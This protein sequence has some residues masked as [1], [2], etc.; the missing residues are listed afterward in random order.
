MEILKLYKTRTMSTDILHYFCFHKNI[1]AK[2]I[3]NS[4]LDRNLKPSGAYLTRFLPH[5]CFC[6]RSDL[7]S[8]L[9]LTPIFIFQSP[10]QIVFFDSNI[11]FIEPTSSHFILPFPYFCSRTHFKLLLTFT[12]ILFSGAWKL[13][14]YSET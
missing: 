9:P 14:T 13:T 1:S 2:Y 7:K 6:S 8:L 12:R 11:Y 4:L 5:P 10:L 3:H